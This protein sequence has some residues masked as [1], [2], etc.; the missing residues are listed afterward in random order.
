MI[1]HFVYR[2]VDSTAMT[3]A[4]LEYAKLASQLDNKT[5]QLNQSLKSSASQPTTMTISPNT[6]KQ[7]QNSTNKRKREHITSVETR[8][9]EVVSKADNSLDVDKA[10]A[11]ENGY[12][13]GLL[14]GDE[15]AKIDSNSNREP[16][17]SKDG[18]IKLEEKSNLKNKNRQVNGGDI[19]KL[20][21]QMDNLESELTNVAENGDL[22]NS[23]NRDLH[24]DLEVNDELENDELE[25]GDLDDHQFRVEKVENAGAGSNKQNEE[26]NFNNFY[27]TNHITDSTKYRLSNRYSRSGAK[28]PP[29]KGRSKDKHDKIDFTTS[30]SSASSSNNRTSSSSNSPN[31]NSTNGN[32]SDN[33]TVLL[34]SAAA[35]SST[36]NDSS[37]FEDNLG[38]ENRCSS[39]TSM[40]SSSN[41]GLILTGR[42]FLDFVCLVHKLYLVFFCVLC[43]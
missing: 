10:G 21:E 36:G 29:I 15:D 27:N 2:H 39:T 9:S 11:L 1:P 20:S 8:D 6:T 16:N 24:L 14:D 32:N 13:N 31:N 35:S 22:D 38:D 25:N 30:L 43:L 23:E 37:T 26:P 28:R 33:T 17:E 41:N 34:S 3:N 19:G 7:Q 40:N 12:K 4:M 42:L 18:L 5:N